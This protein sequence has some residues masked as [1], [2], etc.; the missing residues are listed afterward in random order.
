MAMVS[1]VKVLWKA[2]T[3]IMLNISKEDSQSK[4][5]TV[6]SYSNL[7]IHTTTIQEGPRKLAKMLKVMK[8][9]LKE[10]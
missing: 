8:V 5:H 7:A 4:L 2:T 1:K 9:L 6:A 3:K 10:Y